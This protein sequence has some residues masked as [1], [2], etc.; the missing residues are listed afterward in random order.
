MAPKKQ[1]SPHYLQQLLWALGK[2]GKMQGVTCSHYLRSAHQTHR[3]ST[4]NSTH[5]F[6]YINPWET[7]CDWGR[8]AKEDK[9][10][11]NMQRK[12]G[13]KQE[14]Q[15]AAAVGLQA[16]HRSR[17]GSKRLQLQLACRPAT[18]AEKAASVTCRWAAEQC[19]PF[20]P[21]DRKTRLLLQSGR[22]ISRRGRMA[23]VSTWE[24][25]L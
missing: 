1:H 15:A 12:P 19:L 3:L 25:V 16:I 14:R 21:R 20:F 7:A 8:H 23:G 24:T 6:Y 17:E 5:T 4:L 13:W 9:S 18:A 11:Q 22:R 2:N 10:M